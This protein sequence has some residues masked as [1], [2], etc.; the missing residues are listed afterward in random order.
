MVYDYRIDD[1]EILKKHGIRVID[2]ED[3]QPVTD[4]LKI[5]GD[6]LLEFKTDEQEIFFRMKYL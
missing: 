5:G 4:F 6:L 3:M 1:V 2:Q